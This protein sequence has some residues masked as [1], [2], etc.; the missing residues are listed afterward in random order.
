M[1]NF[2]PVDPERWGPPAWDFLYC[3]AFSYPHYPTDREKKRMLQYLQSLGKILPCQSCRKNY[4][5]K[6]KKISIRKNLDSKKSLVL[7]IMNM[8][9]DI[10]KKANKKLDTYNN[11]CKIYHLDKLE[12]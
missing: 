10:A 11:L 9:N 1:T 8:K 12:F 6:I 3:V 4:K 7:W 2:L 5:Q